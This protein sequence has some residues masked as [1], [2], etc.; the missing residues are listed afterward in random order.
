M[1]SHAI[2]NDNDAPSLEVAV[3]EV[4]DAPGHWLVEAIDH[5]SEGEI[6]RAIF[7]GSMAKQRALDY[8]RLTYGIPSAPTQSSRST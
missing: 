5:A 8:A 2:A 6:Y 4:A 3:V 7:D 1:P